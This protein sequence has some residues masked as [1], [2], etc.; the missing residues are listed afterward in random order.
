M[1]RFCFLGEGGRE[2]VKVI[3]RRIWMPKDE[4]LVRKVISWCHKPPES[5]LSAFTSQRIGSMGKKP[6][7][8]SGPTSLAG[9]Y[10]CP[11]SKATDCFQPG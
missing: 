6:Q 1:L 7:R 8:C 10:V 4:F 5:Q 9:E 3:C 2:G 11:L